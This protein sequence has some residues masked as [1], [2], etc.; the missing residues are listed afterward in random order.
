[1]S[2]IIQI[3]FNDLL[4]GSSIG[5]LLL[6]CI[7]FLLANWIRTRLEQSIRHEYDKKL[8][9]YRFS[10]VQ[11]Q[12]ADMI[13]TF[14]AKWIKYR[15]KERDF[16]DDKELINYY[17]ELNKMSLEISLWINDGEILTDIM[18][19]TQLKDGAGDVWSITGKV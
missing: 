7:Q 16:L 17:E 6:G 10:Q 18:S 19:R 8:E 2:N 1:M 12:K 13:A 9:D 15:G 14:F 11:R 5:V 4:L 3:N